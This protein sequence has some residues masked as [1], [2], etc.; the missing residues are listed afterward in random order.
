MTCGVGWVLPQNLLKHLSGKKTAGVREIGVTTKR[1][2]LTAQNQQVG[3]WRK[4]G[5][6]GRGLGGA[7]GQDEE[8]KDCNGK[9]SATSKLSQGGRR[10]RD[11]FRSPRCGPGESEGERVI[12]TYFMRRIG[13]STEGGSLKVVGR[14]KASSEEGPPDGTLI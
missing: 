5:V 13:N 7:G 1:S 12:A 11:P 3:G 6:S 14:K 4:E 8:K 2:R 9:K 10:L